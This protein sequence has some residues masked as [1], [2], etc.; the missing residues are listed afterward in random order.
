MKFVVT[1]CSPAFHDVDAPEARDAADAF[2]ASD[3]AETCIVFANSVG[4]MFART[5]EGAVLT[6]VSRTPEEAS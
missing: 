3:P 1:P 5:E 4:L 6:K 2:F